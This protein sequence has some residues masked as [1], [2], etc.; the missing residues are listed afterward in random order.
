MDVEVV[1]HIVTLDEY[2]RMCEADVFEPEA[3]TELIRGRIVDMAPIGPA[4][5]SSV[6]RLNFFLQRKLESRA[7][8]WPQGNA[9]RLPAS[10][11]RPQPDIAVLK[12][13]DDFYSGGGPMPEDVLLVVEVSES[14]LKYDRGSKQ[15]LYAEA[16]I[17][18]YWVVNLIDGLVEAYTEPA[19]GLYKSVRKATRGEMLSLPGG[20]EGSIA[21]DDMLG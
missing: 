16:G 6:A 12:W 2:E 3:R 7:L 21:V 19:E 10:N 20:S 18:E 4:H 15:R 5:L 8:V 13:R 9:I 1:P 17:P 11:S 14:S